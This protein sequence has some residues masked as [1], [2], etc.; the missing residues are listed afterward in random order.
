M[1][2]KFLSVMVLLVASLS[3]IKYYYFI[4]YLSF[5]IYR[6]LP[7]Q[8]C[9]IPAIGCDE[10]KKHVR[11]CKK[12]A[13]KIVDY[14]LFSQLSYLVISIILICVAEG[15]KMTEDPLNFNVLNITVEVIR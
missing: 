1:A 11:K 6:Y 15:Q 5:L 14:F 13:K 4:C 12:K 8:T 7:P 9:F 10:D 2:V 3:N